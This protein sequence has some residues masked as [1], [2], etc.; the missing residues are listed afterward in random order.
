MISHN[1]PSVKPKP[2][3]DAMLD[4]LRMLKHGMPVDTGCKTHRDYS[5][6]WSTVR[7]LKRRGL[8]DDKYQ[9]TGVWK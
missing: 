4:V 3:T 6:R 1:A 2:L 5:G 7:A 8:I 9:L